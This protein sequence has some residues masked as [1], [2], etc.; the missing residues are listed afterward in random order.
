M[1]DPKSLQ[2]N[3]SESDLATHTNWKYKDE[4]HVLKKFFKTYPELKM[5]P[6][7]GKLLVLKGG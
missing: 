6:V 2:G 5:M 3:Y 1:L 7:T 4:I